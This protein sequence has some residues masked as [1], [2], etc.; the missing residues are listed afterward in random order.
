[1]CFPVTCIHHTA[2]ALFTDGPLTRPGR[3]AWLDH[4]M[5]RELVGYLALRVLLRAVVPMRT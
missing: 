1:M 3:L 4:V 5:W 2:G